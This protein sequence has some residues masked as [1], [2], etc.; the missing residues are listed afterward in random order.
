MVVMALFQIHFLQN[1]CFWVRMTPGQ[2]HLCHIVTFLVLLSIQK[3]TL[4]VL[5]RTASARQF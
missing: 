5:V 4:W 2:G 3:H 1:A